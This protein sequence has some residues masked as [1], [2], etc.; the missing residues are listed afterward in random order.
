MHK[1]YFLQGT[2]SVNTRFPS[3]II[4]GKV[5]KNFGCFTGLISDRLN[6]GSYLKIFYA[7]LPAGLCSQAAAGKHLCRT[8]LSELELNA[9]LICFFIPP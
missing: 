4:W 5:I 8:G 9:Y 2:G 3:V 6:F 1:L 7:V